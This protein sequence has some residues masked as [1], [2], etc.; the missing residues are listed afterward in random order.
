MFSL[1]ALPTLPTT[2]CISPRKP[3]RH[4][5]HDYFPHVTRL[6]LF[7]LQT[8]YPFLHCFAVSKYTSASPKSFTFNSSS[9]SFKPRAP[10][11]PSVP[12]PPSPLSWA[13]GCKSS[14]LPHFLT[15]YFRTSSPC[16]TCYSIRQFLLKEWLNTSLAVSFSLLGILSGSDTVQ[17]ILL[18]LRKPG[19][20]LKLF[21]KKVKSLSS[22]AKSLRPS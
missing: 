6:V 22:A 15:P 14:Q 4:T 9:I 20:D 7:S 13:T 3:F 16:N 2:F 5:T 8:H 17:K 12:P 1:C 18:L 21:V 19:L 11:Q 10:V